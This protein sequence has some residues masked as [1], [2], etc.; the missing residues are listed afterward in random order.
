MASPIS[1][2]TRAGVS[3]PER[4]SFPID[5]FKEC[6]DIISKYLS[7]ISKHELMPKRCQ[8]LQVEYLNC[9]MEN[10]LMDKETLENLGY[11]KKNS[12]ES[13]IEQKKYLFQTFAKLKEEAEGNVNRWLEEQEK[14][15]LNMDMKDFMRYQKEKE[16]YEK[17]ES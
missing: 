6:T 11:T 15:N 14:D 4:G 17:K 3:P 16:S 10:G 8:K 2:K 1:S 12:F 13:E 5:H 9:R 7:C